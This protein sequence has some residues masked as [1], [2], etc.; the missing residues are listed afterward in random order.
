MANREECRRIVRQLWP[1]L[2]GALPDAIEERVAEHLAG[3]TDC[4]CHFDFEREFL[5][6]VHAHG[7]PESGGNLDTL[8]TRVMGA[9]AADGFPEHRT[10][11]Q[12]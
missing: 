5:A 11:T 1:Y 12:P 7:L 2:D 8:R 4:R 6:A 3:C 9:L 10:S